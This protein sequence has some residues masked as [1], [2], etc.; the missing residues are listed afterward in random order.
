MSLS[1]SHSSTSADSRGVPLAAWLMSIISTTQDLLVRR[2][3]YPA[4]LV[5]AFYA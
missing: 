3:A 4:E 2:E 1:L 5:M